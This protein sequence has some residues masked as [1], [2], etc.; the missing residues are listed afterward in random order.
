MQMGRKAAETTAD[1][2]S[3]TDEPENGVGSPGPLPTSDDAWQSDSWAPTGQSLTVIL[4][5][6]LLPVS[7]PWGPSGMQ[8]P[9]QNTFYMHVPTP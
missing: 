1:Q 9:A 8:V 6:A 7:K 5:S 2:A 4:L 3:K